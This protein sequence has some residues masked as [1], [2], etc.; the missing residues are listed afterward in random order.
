MDECYIANL[1]RAEVLDLEN[2]F[3]LF[4]PLIQDMIVHGL[5]TVAD[6]QDDVEYSDLAEL[7]EGF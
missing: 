7:F 6:K 2:T 4:D 1:P 5:R 3:H